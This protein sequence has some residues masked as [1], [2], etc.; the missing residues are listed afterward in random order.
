[1][2][3]ARSRGRVDWLGLEQ[4]SDDDPA[5][6]LAR[7]PIRPAQLVGDALPVSAE[8]DVVDPAKTVKIVSNNRSGHPVSRFKQQSASVCAPRGMTP[9]YLQSV[10]QI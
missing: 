8:P 5:A 7:L 6:I 2:I 3:A 9:T 4:A 10:S 1:V